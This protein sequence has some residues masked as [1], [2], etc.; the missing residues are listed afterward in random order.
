MFQKKEE[1]KMWDQN[2]KRKALDNLP[3]P[4]LQ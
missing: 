1:E 4:T 3:T 2:K